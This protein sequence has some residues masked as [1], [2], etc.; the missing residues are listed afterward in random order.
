[1]DTT[2]VASYSVLRLAFLDVVRNCKKESA[3]HQPSLNSPYVILLG[4]NTKFKEAQ[5]I[6]IVRNIYQ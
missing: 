1:M 4:P 3:I 2:A 5:H 6:E